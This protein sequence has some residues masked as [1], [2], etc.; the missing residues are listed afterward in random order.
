MDKILKLLCHPKTRRMAVE[1]LL[2][3]A[4]ALGYRCKKK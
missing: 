2:I 1:A 3:L 4:A